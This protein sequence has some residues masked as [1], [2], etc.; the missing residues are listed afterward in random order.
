MNL[1]S[2]QT[3][4]PKSSLKWARLVSGRDGHGPCTPLPI[5]MYENFI[6]QTEGTYDSS[7]L[8]CHSITCISLS[9]V[10]KSLIHLTLG[11]IL[12]FFF[13]VISS[14]TRV[15][16]KFKKMMRYVIYHVCSCLILGNSHFHLKSILI[17][18]HTTPFN[19]PVKERN[20]LNKFPKM[21]FCTVAHLERA[22]H[23]EP[24]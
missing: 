3:H 7:I 6:H 17:G 2:K 1:G 18:E 22:F 24:I 14:A 9:H 10:Q 4:G 12:S 15:P 13:F 11:S 23:L 8:Y 16:T 5:H 19:G 21:P 20:G